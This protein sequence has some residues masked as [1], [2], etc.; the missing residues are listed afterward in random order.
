MP[1]LSYIQRAWTDLAGNYCKD[2][3]IVKHLFGAIQEAYTG[4]QRYYHNLHHVENLLGLSATYGGAL[5]HKDIVDFSIF[6]HDIVYVAGRGDNEYQSALVAEKA[7]QQLG[8]QEEGIAQVRIFIQATSNHSHLPNAD[9]D[10][11]LFIDF[12][13][14]IL[15]AEREVYKNYV[16][17]IRREYGHIPSE[18]FALGRKGFI[19]HLL[20]QAH[21]FHTALFREREDQA[22]KNMQ[23]E[24]E[25]G[26]GMFS[27]C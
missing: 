25:M 6:Y 26:A 11:K 21:I 16:L 22:R 15:A 9:E 18:Q 19:Q 24:V 20:R 3:T 10:L 23:W 12:D 2:E 7:L 8:L 17:N 4:A 5:N 1:D 27:A 14:S 13:L